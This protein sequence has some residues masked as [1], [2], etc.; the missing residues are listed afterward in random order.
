MSHI[1]RELKYEWFKQSDIDRFCS[2]IITP[3]WQ[4]NPDICWEMDYHKNKN[5]YYDTFKCSN[6]NV[7]R[8]HR[9]AYCLANKCDVPSDKFI[10]HKC[11]NSG[12][13]NPNHL[14]LG[15]HKDNMKYMVDSG[16]SLI[17]EKHHRSIFSDDCVW[18]LLLRIYNDEF[19]SYRHI[20]KTYDCTITEIS[21]ILNGVIRKHITDEFCNKYKITLFDLQDKCY[22]IEREYKNK[23][24][25]ELIRQIRADVHLSTR[26]LAKKY[27]MGH[28]TARRIRL[29]I[30]YKDVK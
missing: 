23:F 30:A 27:R 26:Q 4:D 1:C 13:V 21:H 3:N 11:N 28:E 16:R 9:A 19:K 12:C 25:D 6:S 15:T 22:D 17:G 24:S 20:A 7:I 18:N 10:L 29:G 14:E 5:G 8:A 2:H